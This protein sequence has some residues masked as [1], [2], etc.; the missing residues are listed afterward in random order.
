MIL[1][2]SQ[3]VYYTSDFL[4]QVLSCSDIRQVIKPAE[5]KSGVKNCCHKEHIIIKA[6]VLSVVICLTLK[7]H[8]VAKTVKEFHKANVQ[9]YIN[10]NSCVL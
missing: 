5:T 9:P 3:K 8:C 4:S 7:W 2:F 10:I 6:E 1:E